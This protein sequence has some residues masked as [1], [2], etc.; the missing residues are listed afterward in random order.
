[1]R[2]IPKCKVEITLLSF[3]EYCIG[4]GYFLNLKTNKSL[5]CLGRGSAAYEF[6][7]TLSTGHQKKGEEKE[8]SYFN[9]QQLICFQLIKNVTLLFRAI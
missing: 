1:M 5:M 2:I 3:K 9:N 6:L 8:V 7:Q 4:L